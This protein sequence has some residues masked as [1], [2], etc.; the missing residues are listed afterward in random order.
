VRLQF[1]Y[2][3]KE[4]AV[5]MQDIQDEEKKVTLQGTI[6]GLDSKELRNGSTLFTYYLTDF[7]DSLQMKMFAKTKEDL[8]IL[9]LL[10]NG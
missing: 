3:I 8:K 6:F 7:S 4:P 1:G 5:P 9:S 2:D 10:A